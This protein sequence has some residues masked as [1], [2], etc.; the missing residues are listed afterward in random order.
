[1]TSTGT[2]YVDNKDTV[3]KEAWFKKR[4]F[5]GEI[6]RAYS[7]RWCVL[8]ARYFEWYDFPVRKA[9]KVMMKLVFVSFVAPFPSTGA[10]PATFS[11]RNMELFEHELL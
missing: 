11:L 6:G 8:T 4:N 9:R 10:L 1:M 5:K 7:R 2:N 3:I